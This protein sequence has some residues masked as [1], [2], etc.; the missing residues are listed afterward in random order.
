MPGPPHTGQSRRMRPSPSI[1]RRAHEIDSDRH[2]ERDVKHWG[3]CGKDETAERCDAPESIRSTV[4]CSDDGNPAPPPDGVVVVAHDTPPPPSSSSVDASR[5][6]CTTPCRAPAAW[7]G[8]R[9]RPSR[10]P[11]GGV[12]PRGGGR[13]SPSQRR[14][15]GERSLRARAA[16]ANERRARVRRHVCVFVCVRTTNERTSRLPH[17][18]VDGGGRSASTLRRAFARTLSPGESGH[19]ARSAPPRPGEP[20]RRRRTGARVAC[21]ARIVGRR[22]ASVSIIVCR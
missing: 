19:A 4:T 1:G 7:R 3:R 14:R 21:V 2:C 11:I 8:A 9:A 13:W 18:D 5:A 10:S 15:G 6:M 22:S 17:L 20:H 16:V 12:R